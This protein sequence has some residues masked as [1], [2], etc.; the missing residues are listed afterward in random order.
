MLDICWFLSEPIYCFLQYWNFKHRIGN[1][2]GND[3]IQMSSEADI[4]LAILNPKLYKIVKDP[5]QKRFQFTLED[6]V[7]PSNEVKTE[8]MPTKMPKLQ[9]SIPK[10][11]QIEVGFTHFSIF[12]SFQ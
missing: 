7:L 4:K 3:Q 1:S 8:P 9:K 6:A 12:F 2:I 11:L 5:V 10:P